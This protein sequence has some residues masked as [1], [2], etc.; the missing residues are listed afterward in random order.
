MGR[1]QIVIAAVVAALMLTALADAAL[2]ENY[3]YERT[4]KDD[5]NAKAVALNVQGG[6]L[7]AVQSRLTS[8]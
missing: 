5:A 8:T 1:T 3:Q 2:S 6:V 7:K 4:G